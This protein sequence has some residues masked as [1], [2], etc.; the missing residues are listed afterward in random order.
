[1]LYS[2]LQTH[3]SIVSCGKTNRQTEEQEW[4]ATD[5]QNDGLR[6]REKINEI[7]G[8]DHLQKQM[9]RLVSLAHV[10]LQQHPGATVTFVTVHP[11]PALSSAVDTRSHGES[12]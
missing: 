9:L 2:C 1:M 7:V 5:S 10:Y 4:K 8:T 12:S 11:L 3:W 6:C